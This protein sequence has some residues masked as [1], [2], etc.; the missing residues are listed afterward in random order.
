MGLIH[1]DSEHPDEWSEPE[2]DRSELPESSEP[3]GYEKHLEPHQIRNMIVSALELLHKAAC[4]NGDELLMVTVRPD[5]LYASKESKSIPGFD[6]DR[7]LPGSLSNNMRYA[8]AARI[9]VPDQAEGEG[10]KT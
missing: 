3:C 9:L 7:S 4:A 6:L 5:K 2:W 1:R 8:E 10:K